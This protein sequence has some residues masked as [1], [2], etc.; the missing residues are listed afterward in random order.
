M[1]L[2]MKHG[3]LILAT[4]TL[5]AG[6]ATNPVTGRSEFSIISESQELAIGAQQYGP[7]RQSQ[8]G[9]F[10]ADPVLTAY[11]NQ[12]GQRVAAVSDRQ[13]PYE[14]VVLNNSVPNAW[15]LPGGKIAINR[16]LL[17][18]LNNE[19]ELAA[20]LGHEVVHSAARHGALAVTRGS[21][22]QG[23]LMVGAFATR[24][25]EFSDFI[26]G[27]SMLGAQLISQSYG[28]EAEREADYYG[29]E[30]M[31]RAG[32]DPQ[33]AV[34]LQ[35]TFLRLSG[36]RRNT[37]WLE[38]L[39]SSHPPSQERVRN[40]QA[41]VNEMM[42]RL[43]G[44]ELLLGELP[45]Q[46]AIAS[47]KQNQ[48]AYDLFD[49]AHR[50]IARDDLETA[51]DN[52]DRAIALVPHEAT[53]HGLKGD[54]FLYQGRYREAIGVYD[55]ALTLDSEY[56][57]YYMGR[58]VAN[59]RLG[60]SNQAR[61]DLERSAALLPTAMSMNEL[62]KL[63]LAGNDRRSAKQYFQAA[64]GSQGRIG[65]EASAAFMRLD[66]QDN[67]ANYLQ[68]QALIDNNGRVMARVQN[69]SGVALSNIS[70]DFAV[71]SEGRVA[72]PNQVIRSLAANASVNINAGITLPAE[73][74]GAAQVTAVVRSAQVL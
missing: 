66:V 11:V 37:S 40:N 42:P 39:F 1:R 68:I 53:F 57:D 61:A 21:L 2:I 64:A 12:V 65:Q 74:R 41:Q 6:C 23:A 16:G 15:A 60:A 18:E 26:V 34:S 31:V 20:V 67:P 44:R 62:G 17:V 72:R 38:G 56:Y 47:L 27:G 63:A 71:S 22:L 10:S 52:L 54:I 14:F 3:L 45:Y 43:T 35:E 58:G 51:L 9:D 32:Y 5:L 19:A 4:L 36:D 55:H 73:V 8:G 46:Q 70:I 25:N 48:P 29:I 50:A 49:Q 7:M 13:L 59:A 28:R 33:A 30:Y 69:R 24:N